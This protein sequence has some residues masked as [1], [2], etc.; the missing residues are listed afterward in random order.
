[1]SI[2]PLL[3]FSI[4]EQ[5]F[6]RFHMGRVYEIFW[7]VFFYFIIFKVRVRFASS[8]NSPEIIVKRLDKDE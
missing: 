2:Y 5:F 7:V 8:A 6:V 3:Y 4:A 1:M